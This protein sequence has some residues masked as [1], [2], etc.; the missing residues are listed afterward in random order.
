M[1]KIKAKA[2]AEG[3]TEAEAAAFSEALLRMLVEHKIEIHE[4]GDVEQSVDQTLINWEDHGRMFKAKR[5]AWVESLV[6]VVA[7]AHGCRIM[8]VSGTNKIILC[9]FEASRMLAVEV[10]CL[11]VK[12]AEAQAQ[13]AYNKFYHQCWK[14]GDVSQ[15]KGY[16]SSYLYGFIQRVSERYRALKNLEGDSCQALVL[17]SNDLVKVD[18]WLEAKVTKRASAI[19][20]N[21]KINQ[22]AYRKGRVD[23]NKVEIRK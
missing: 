18:D 3:T 17:I 16:R 1:R 19:G 20:T 2:E 7:T 8:V 14:N 13:K 15:A 21:K 23:G 6:G 4:L 22:E 11:L 9:G 5:E 10:A 12:V